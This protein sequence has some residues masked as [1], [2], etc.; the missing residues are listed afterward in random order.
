[1]WR[2]YL[3]LLLLQLTDRLEDAVYWSENRERR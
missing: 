3:A 2:G 1:V